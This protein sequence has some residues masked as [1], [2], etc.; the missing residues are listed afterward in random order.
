MTDVRGR[1]AAGEIVA[2]CRDDLAPL[3]RAMLAA[4]AQRDR[5][6]PALHDGSRVQFGWSVLTLRRDNDALRVC[7]PDFGGDPFADFSARVDVSLAVIREQAAVLR[8]TGATGM[9]ARWD[10][11]VIIVPATA[12]AAPGVFLRREAPSGP[13]DSG[14]LIGDVD[15]PPAQAEV[16]A[17]DAV[18][19]YRLLALRP[20][21]LRLLALPVGW[22]IRVSGE[23]IE[24]VIDVDGKTQW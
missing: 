1:V 8:R 21:L 7:E 4:F 3:A 23:R 17:A 20:F 10:A 16:E 24:E 13:E 22:F 14:W 6:G 5:A 18:P 2:A 19:V 12:L 9:D 15:H 11:H